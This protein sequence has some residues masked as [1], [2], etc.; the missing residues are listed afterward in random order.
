MRGDD[1]WTE[2][3]VAF[4]TVSGSFTIVGTPGEACCSRTIPVS[5]SPDEALN[6]SVDGRDVLRERDG[7][8]W[9]S[10]GWFGVDGAVEKC[11]TS[12]ESRAESIICG[13]ALFAIYKPDYNGNVPCR[14]VI[15]SIQKNS[16][17]IVTNLSNLL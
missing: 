11:S 7:R 15:E 9:M 17:S 10:S 14:H 1:R 3:E 12:G 13:S 6:W 16:V 8:I 5:Q 2:T 4:V